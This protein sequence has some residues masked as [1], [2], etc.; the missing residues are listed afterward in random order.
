MVTALGQVLPHLC[1]GPSARSGRFVAASSFPRGPCGRLACR[2]AAG[3]IGPFRRD[4][5]EFRWPFMRVMH[6]L[7]AVQAGEGPVLEL[8]HQ[9]ADPGQ[10]G[11]P[12]GQV[13]FG[14]QH[15]QP[16]QPGEPGKLGTHLGGDRL[17]QR[18]DPVAQQLQRPAR[19]RPR[20]APTRAASNCGYSFTGMATS[21]AIQSSS[22]LAA[23]LG[24]LVHGAF[25]PPSSRPAPIASMSPCRARLFTTVY[26]EP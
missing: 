2:R 9:A 14:L 24:D 10:L 1:R 16:G 12:H 5:A 23:R 26:S 7:P 13:V 11:L 22:L 3:L 15:E 17:L 19:G 25:R 20:A 8:G 6:V 21:S 18:A 4:G